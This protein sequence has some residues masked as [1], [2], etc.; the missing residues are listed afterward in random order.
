[1]KNYRDNDY[2]LNKVN[3]TAVVY[4][5]ATETVEITLDAYLRE[6]PGKTEAGF[7]ELKT[8]S[9]ADYLEIDRSDYRQTYLNVSIHGLAETCVCS[10]PSPEDEFIESEFD[11]P[12]REVEA[13][14]R[15][16][17]GMRAF[18]TLTEVQRRRYTQHY[19]DGLSTRQIADL[20]GSNHKSVHESIK[21]A[22]KKVKK[23]FA[24]NQK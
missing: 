15:H 7:A 20:E 9:D 4:R 14:Q 19:V 5:F 18:G 6:N 16:E 23:F 2:A 21:S 8:L 13:E 12:E 17:L 10:S 11:R 1:M 3:K 22:E 24:D